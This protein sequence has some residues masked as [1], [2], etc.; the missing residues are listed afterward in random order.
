M[1]SSNN[2]T[3]TTNSVDTYKK[4]LDSETW[5]L[6]LLEKM[7]F[8][9]IEEQRRAR[10][11]RIFVQLITLSYLLLVLLL[12]LDI[13]MPKD[14]S[15]SDGHAARIDIQGTISDRGDTDALRINRALQEAFADTNTKGVV[16]YANSP[17]GSPVQSGMIYREIIRLKKEHPNTPVYAVVSDLCASGCYYI[18]AA[19]DKIYADPASLVGSI[20]VRFDSFGFVDLFQKIGVERRLVTAG[21][22]K[23][24]LDPF[25]PVDPEQKAHVEGLLADIH[26]QFIQAVRDGRGARLQEDEKIFSGLIWT[27]EAGIPLGLVDELADLSYVAKTVIGTEN[28]VR[29][30]Q[31]RPLDNFFTSMTQAFWRN[32][33]NAFTLH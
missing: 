12:V 27:G 32:M 19:A 23:G 28:I 1:E 2:T 13:E 24:L 15:I 20:G 18:V 5:S 8:A 21:E 4:S 9:S 7:L 29:Y 3:Q 30:G 16:L 26:Q 31:K 14:F 22:N 11:W 6:S 33:T 25:L 17:G 10:R